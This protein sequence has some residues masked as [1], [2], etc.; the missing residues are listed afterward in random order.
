MTRAHSIR[1]G[2]TDTP[3]SFGSFPNP[4]GS[5]PPEV[6]SK[7]PP[8]RPEH[9]RGR[10]LAPTPRGSSAAEP[11]PPRS[12]PISKSKK[13]WLEWSAR[14][15][16]E[17]TT[18]RIFPR[19]QGAPCEEE[20]RPQGPQTW[21]A[22]TSR[23]P[24]RPRP[25]PGLGEVGAGLVR[26]R[27]RLPSPRARP[28]GGRERLKVSR[29]SPGRRGAGSGVP[30]G[31]G[32]RREAGRA[33]GA[34][35]AS[36]GGRAA[37]AEEGSPPPPRRGSPSPETAA[38]AKPGPGPRAGRPHSPRSSPGARRA[39]GPPGSGRQCP[40]P[41]AARAA[42][43][44]PQ[45][46]T[47]GRSEL[48]GASFRGAGPSSSAMGRGRARD[49]AWARGLPLRPA[50]RESVRGRAERAD[51]APLPRQLLSD[52]EQA[53]RA[54]HARRPAPPRAYLRLPA[55]PLAPATGPRGT[56]AAARPGERGEGGTEGEG[57]AGG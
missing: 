38:G 51:D 9:T 30:G 11:S 23:P 18:S 48:R 8:P 10:S 6:P 45:G 50:R 44:P 37:G 24:A 28:P 33:G 17:S 21:G 40:A 25:A 13:L 52:P 5:S 7:E 34:A 26:T 41:A 49:G 56:A 43:P 20:E 54:P 16:A 22:G 53:G 55:Q 15:P 39:P 3:L 47:W 42:S 19:H 1:T 36:R 4:P 35:P 31:A 32:G 46:S 12:R 27:R 57:A 2:S 29:A 14:S